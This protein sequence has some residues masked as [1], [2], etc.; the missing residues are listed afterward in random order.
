VFFIVFHRHCEEGD[1]PT[2]LAPRASA[3]SNLM[4]NSWDC[5]GLLRKSIALAMTET[6]WNQL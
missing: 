1:S 3:V 6:K 4:I 2:T 5:F